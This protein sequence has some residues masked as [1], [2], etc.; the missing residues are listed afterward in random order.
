[1][2]GFLASAYCEWLKVSGLLLLLLLLVQVL[3]HLKE[4]SQKFITHTTASVTD[5]I[6]KVGLNTFVNVTALAPDTPRSR[7]GLPQQWGPVTQYGP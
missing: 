6:T 3:L 1:M 2:R 7:Q 5:N 4:R